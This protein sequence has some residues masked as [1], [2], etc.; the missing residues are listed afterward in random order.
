MLADARQRPAGRQAFA[1]E[2]ERQQRHLG[3][4]PRFGDQRGKPAASIE[5]RIVEQLLRLDDRRIRQSVRLEPLLQLV[6]GVLPKYLLQPRDEP[7]ARQDA[8]IVG[9]NAGIGSEL[10][11]SEH[12]AEDLPLGI[13]HHA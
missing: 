1:V 13:A 9:S 3:F 11:Q 5:M 6:H 12:L 2:R 10:A 7:L 8:L 4:L